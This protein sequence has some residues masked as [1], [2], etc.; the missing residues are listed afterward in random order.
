MRFRPEI[1]LT[2]LG[3]AELLLGHHPG[4]RAEAIEQLDFAIGEF[5]AMKMA[6]RLER[7]LGRKGM[8]G[9]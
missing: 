7:A 3:L 2:H 8:V 5:R 1:A 9:A 6:P 4:R